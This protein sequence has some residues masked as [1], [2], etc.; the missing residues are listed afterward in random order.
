MVRAF[1][2]WW[3]S[4]QRAADLQLLWPV[5]KQLAPDLDHAKAAFAFHAFNDPAWIDAFGEAGLIEAIN[6]LE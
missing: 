4:R 6:R 5:C 3:W 2:S 1:Q